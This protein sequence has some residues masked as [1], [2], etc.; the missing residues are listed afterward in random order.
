MRQKTSCVFVLLIWC[1]F[2]ALAQTELEFQQFTQKDGLSS[3]F[4]LAIKQDYQGFIWVGTE[5]G[6]NRFDGQ[7]FLEFRFDPEDP[8]TLS[9]NWAGL[10]YEDSKNNLWIGSKTG[11]NKLNREKG[12]IERIPLFIGDQQVTATV[13]SLFEVS[14]SQFWLTTRNKGLF[15]LEKNQLDQPW[16]ATRI[17]YSN[18]ERDR[19]AGLFYFNVPYATPNEV[20]L[21][22]SQGIDRIQVKEK[23][24]R[25]Y[26]YPN[27]SDQSQVEYDQISGITNNNEDVFVGFGDELYVLNTKDL[28]PRLRPVKNHNAT[29]DRP[30]TITRKMVFDDQGRL[31]IPS[32]RDLEI[33]NLQNGK[34]HLV[35]KKGQTTEHLFTNGIHALLQD[36]Q[37]NYWIGTSGEG[38]YLGQVSNSAFTFYQHDP[39]DPG[40]ISK[41]QVRSIIEDN[42]GNLWT[43]I[44]QHGLDLL[45]FNE[46]NTLVREKTVRPVPG[47]VN[48]L[49]TAKIIKLLR[50]SDNSIWVATNDNGLLQLDEEGIQRKVYT[51]DPKDPNSLSGERIWGLAQDQQGFIWAGSWK[52]GLNRINPQTGEIKQYHHNPENENS[53]LSE[54]IRSLYIDEEGIIWIGTLIGLCRFDPQL[55][56]FTHFQHEAGNPQSLSDNLI[57]SIF[58]DQEGILW[59]GTE[60]G[61]N[62]YKAQTGDFESF[63]EKD[64]LPNNSIYG[65][66]AD[67]EGVIW[68]STKDGLAR[69]LPD[70]A[71]QAFFPLGFS[72]GLET[73][74]FL[75]KAYLNSSK[76]ET[77][78]FGSTEGIL[79]V[80][81]SMLNA[82]N[83]EP[84]L[85]IH[86]ISVFNPSNENSGERT[87]FFIQNDQP[88]M[89]LGYRDQSVTLRLSDLNWKGD[90]DLYYEYQLVGFNRQWM[91]VAENK[92]I[93]FTN[94]PPG[95]YTLQAR[96][97]NAE[98][99]ISEPSALINFQVVPPLW[100][101]IWAYAMYLILLG[102]IIF[103]V[104]RFQLRR[105]FEKQEA[106]NL[107]ALDNFKNQLYTN[108]THEF[109]TPLT[110]ITGMLDQME[111]YPKTRFQQGMNMIRRNS[112]NLL[113]LVNQMLD[114]QKVQTGNLQV[115]WQQGDILPFLNSI[116]TQFQAFAQS[117]EQQMKFQCELESLHMDYDAEKILRIVSNLLSNAIKY[118]PEQGVIEMNV[119]RNLIGSTD[120]NLILTVKDTGPGIP[121]NQLPQ[122]FDRYFQVDHSGVGT[123]I[124]LS[125]TQELVQ[126]LNGNIEVSSE[127]GHGT[128]FQIHLPITGKAVVEVSEVESRIPNAVFGQFDNFEKGPIPSKDLPLALIVEDNPDITAYLQLCLEDNY[129]LA[130]AKNGE[131]G[132][133]RAIESIP[134]IIISDVMMPVKNGFELCDTLKQDIRT[135]H[136]PIIM[137]T[138][139]S[140]V[141]SR[142]KGLKQGADDYLAKPFNEEE[143]LV[144]M[145]NLLDTRRKLQER[146][147]DLY[148][149]PLPKPGDNAPNIEDAF[150]QKVKA[151]LEERIV[152]VDFSLD[153]LSSEL[154]LS[155]SQMGRKVKALTGRS[156][157]I[158]VRSLRLQKARQLLLNSTLSVKE[159]AYEVGFSDPAYFTRS[160][161]AEYGESPSETR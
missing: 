97:K 33:Y 27:S 150:I 159:I 126:L 108:I 77:L 160:F 96:A 55:N 76:S 110:I 130:F 24:F 21:A 6:L 17:D 31:L 37:G 5:N 46:K 28:S 81:P 11:L 54:N 146:Y 112:S 134:D 48:A 14:P 128:T 115:N 104:Y 47:K 66:L 75:P 147:Q 38:L 50:G 98:N 15:K 22:Q 26:P 45:T 149:Q 135:S 123:G 161:T 56:Q 102:A 80:Q 111:K 120:R 151:V 142:I 137:L 79:S 154:N 138:A 68:A 39:S 117:K 43:G 49:A 58:K 63:Y 32:F 20:W 103:G 113:D 118:T 3:N 116:F 83:P 82:N 35:R 133:D 158:Y 12:C 94:L 4:I 114:L 155:R 69:E 36:Q 144:R 78:Y 67:E 86:S 153:A 57:W 95:S 107:R 89:R 30:F 9:D 90:K 19:T 127:V 29:D 72:N 59:V 60:T 73:V 145:K 92:Q 18:G 16:Q 143:L 84:Q 52:N 119:S 23:T 1:S 106:D 125:L 121:A 124:G 105:Q 41:G 51:Y 61:L 62:K 25:Y 122:I 40:T 70:E 141:S 140:D 13:N 136:I 148:N 7:N 8:N 129:K 53:L 10:L 152:D 109:R 101:S 139:K 87:D 71:E 156:L 88:A 131:E 91:P 2:N 65:I 34:R 132:I 100:K 99:L 64:G 74:S 157:S 44:I 93:S 85:N 42:Q